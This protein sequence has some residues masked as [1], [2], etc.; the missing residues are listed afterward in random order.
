MGVWVGSS[1]P[2]HVK[3]VLEKTSKGIKEIRAES[4]FFSA[5]SIAKQFNHHPGMSAEIYSNLFAKIKDCAEFYDEKYFHAA[6]VVENNDYYKIMIKM[7]K[8]G[9]E[10]Y[11]ISLFKLRDNQLTHLRQYGKRI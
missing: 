5:D 3:G 6:L 2:Q 4:L 11:I 7:T 10:V 9:S 8:D 1:L